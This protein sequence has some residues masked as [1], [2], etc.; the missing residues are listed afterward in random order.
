MR[1]H[2]LSDLH[3][4]M[5]NMAAPDVEADVTILAGDIWRPPEAAMTWAA[6]FARP[7]L[8]V[9]G[10]HEFYGGSVDEV[11]RELAEAARAHGV[12]LLDQ[13]VRVID[14]VRFVGTT[15]WTDF[16][17]DGESRRHEAMTKSAEVMLDFRIVR[18]DDGST[19]TPADS[20]ALFASQYAW[21]A[22]VLDEPFGGPSVV[23]THHAPAPQSVH[24]RFASS[25][26][27]PAFVSDCTDL[28]G[29]APL[30]VHGHTHD[31]FDYAV[32]GTRV[33]CNAR[34]YWRDGKAENA[35]FDPCLCIDVP[36]TDGDTTATLT[37]GR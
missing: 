28:M 25:P 20:C 33:V 35:N 6:S 17:L 26:I 1:L 23:I 18:N 11:R 37:G 10:N 30:W 13:G 21:L 3:L 32:R 29:R 15:L 34:G 2:I 19:F 4:G 36:T 8:F 22:R 7:V 31:S 24:P 27:N 16:L 5:Q 12:I 9:P 14:R